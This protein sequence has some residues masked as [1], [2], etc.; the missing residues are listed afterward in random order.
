MFST[1]MRNKYFHFESIQN[2]QLALKMYK[3]PIISKENKIKYS[4]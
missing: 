3:I 4:I 2:S 1:L